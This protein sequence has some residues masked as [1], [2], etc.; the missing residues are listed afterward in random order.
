MASEEGM[1]SGLVIRKVSISQREYEDLKKQK[2]AAKRHQRKII[3]LEGELSQLKKEKE[4]NLI[5]E[6]L[7]VM[8]DFERAIK[9]AEERQDYPSILLGIEAI[10]RE[11]LQI[12]RGK[13]VERFESQGQ[14]F[15]PAIHQALEVSEG[16]DDIEKA[17]VIEELRPG[18]KMGGQ[19]IRKA[20]VRLG[21]GQE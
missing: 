19:I 7:P 14:R 17:L 11:I 10:R 16:I 6:F 21:K 5:L 18:Y 20:L 3:K 4:I 2:E 13:D 1:S 12:L 15:D 9:A 8:D